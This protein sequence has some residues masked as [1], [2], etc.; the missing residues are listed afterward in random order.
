MCPSDVYFLN[1][2][3]KGSLGKSREGAS[4]SH[5]NAGESTAKK[6]LVLMVI[7]A[8]HINSLCPYTSLGSMRTWVPAFCLPTLQQT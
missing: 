1:M 8:A 4:E 5:G 2:D 7:V 6:V 3:K